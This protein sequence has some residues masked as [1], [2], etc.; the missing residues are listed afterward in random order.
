MIELLTK[1]TVKLVIKLH[2]VDIHRHWLRQ[3][4]QA[5][6]LKI[7]WVPTTQMPADGLTKALSHQKHENFLRLLGLVNIREHLKE[8]Y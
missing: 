6:R 8:V 5:G 2:H 4:V 7:N 3:E 1:N